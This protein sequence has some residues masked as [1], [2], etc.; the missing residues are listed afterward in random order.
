MVGMV[1]E[2]LID[3]GAAFYTFLHSHKFITI[4]MYKLPF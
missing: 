3:K 1:R 4:R 2:I